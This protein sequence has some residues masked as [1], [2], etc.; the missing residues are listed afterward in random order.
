MAPADDKTLTHLLDGVEQA[1]RGAQV[2]FADIL[3]EFGD[4]AITPF[5]LI[6]ALLLV[7]PLSGIPGTPTL[8]AILLV[9]LS[10]QA[11]AGRQRLWLPARLLRLELRADR[12]R[13]AVDWMRRPCA[14]LDRHSQ[15]RLRF[16]TVGPMRSLALL[17]CLLIPLT[18]PLLEI[19]PFFTSFGAG[20]V[21]LMSLGLILRDGI[22]VLAG[23]GIVGASTVGLVLAL[24]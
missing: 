9:T 16:L 22:Y 17:T 20:T 10:A 23:F 13:R 3:D 19:L 7:S 8:A 4:R 6:I 15:E 24:N 11:L 21:S 14:W 5:I 1:A 12:V 2:S 18:W